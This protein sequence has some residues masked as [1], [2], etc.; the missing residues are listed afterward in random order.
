M[1]GA[2]AG[3]AGRGGHHSRQRVGRCQGR[4]LCDRARS[5]DIGCSSLL[6]FPER[7][8]RDGLQRFASVFTARSTG[9]AA[10]NPSAAWLPMGALGHRAALVRPGQM[11]RMAVANP[12][13]K[14]STAQVRRDAA[15][16]ASS[17]RLLA[18]SFSMMRLT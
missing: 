17:M 15:L 16:M 2:I 9:M 10:F 12:D 3:H 18:C 5:S 8:I 13:R 6:R 7:V 1:S 4:F 11:L 14:G